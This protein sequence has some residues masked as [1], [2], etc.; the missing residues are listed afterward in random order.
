MKVRVGRISE[1]RENKVMRVK[2][3]TS[4]VKGGSRVHAK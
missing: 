2:I 1:E 3:Q 4:R